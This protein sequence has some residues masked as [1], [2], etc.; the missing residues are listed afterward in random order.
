[1][2]WQKGNWSGIRGGQDSGK[3]F[4]P[5]IVSEGPKNE[6]WLVRNKFEETPEKVDQRLSFEG[7]ADVENVE[8]HKKKLIAEMALLPDVTYED[9]LI[10]IAKA[11][12]QWS[13]PKFQ[14][15]PDL[16]RHL[17]AQISTQNTIF[18]YPKPVEKPHSWNH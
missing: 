16:N 4:L 1:M 17:E 2:V 11:G 15:Y 10:N 14:R 6:M 18:R 8:W 12:N 5:P 9:R 7:D 13:K 3:T